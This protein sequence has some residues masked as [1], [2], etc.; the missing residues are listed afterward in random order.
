M[1]III[2]RD[3][4]EN[5]ITCGIY[6]VAF[7]IVVES[8]NKVIQTV[9]SFFSIKQPWGSSVLLA[10]SAIC[11]SSS[12]FD[13][14]NYWKLFGVVVVFFI[15]EQSLPFFM[16]K[17]YFLKEEFPFNTTGYDGI[18]DLG[19]L[20]MWI[21]TSLPHNQLPSLEDTYWSAEQVFTSALL[22]GMAMGIEW[23]G[24]TIETFI[25]I[26]MKLMIVLRM[27]RILRK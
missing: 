18:T 22:L 7:S 15:N 11:I 8:L 9:T 3:S 14:F 21:Y 2:V 23:S 13:W 20:T 6:I 5:K 19:L 24:N 16:I 17:L 12:F 27:L 1:M 26:Y 10:I 4:I 25:T